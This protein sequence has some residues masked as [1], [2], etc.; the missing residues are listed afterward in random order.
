MWKRAQSRYSG[1]FGVVVFLYVV[2]SDTRIDLL[3]ST[4][5]EELVDRQYPEYLLRE[6]CLRQ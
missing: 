1:F 6:V 5:L 3:T 2:S 4:K